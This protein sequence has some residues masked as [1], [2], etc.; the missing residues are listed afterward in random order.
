MFKI[1]D[2]FQVGN[3]FSVTFE[4]ACDAIKNGSK[5]KDDEGNTYDVI[6]VGMTKYNNPEDISKYTTVL[7][8]KCNLTKGSILYIA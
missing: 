6:S 1:I 7:L 3:N 5:L 4:G 2:V 8:N